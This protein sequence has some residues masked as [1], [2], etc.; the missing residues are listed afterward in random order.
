MLKMSKPLMSIGTVTEA[1]SGVRPEKP[2][3]GLTLD[4]YKVAVKSCYDIRAE[5]AEVQKRLKSLI[6]KRD[7]ADAAA[8]QLTKNIVH[9]VKADP[10]EGENSP[11]YAAM[12]YVRASDRSSGLTR[13]RAPAPPASPASPP[14]APKEVTATS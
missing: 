7:D 11:L 2:F 13:V 6:A 12:G 5:I 3:F 14:A 1:W 8:L 9:A 4:Q 10:T